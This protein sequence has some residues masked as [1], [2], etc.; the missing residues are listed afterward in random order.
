MNVGNYQ[1]LEQIGMT[2]GGP[3][4]LARELPAGTSALLKLPA[5]D[6]AADGLRRE[7]GLL[8]SLDAPEILKPLALLEE[9]PHLALVLEAFAGEGLDAV[10]ARP[11]QLGLPKALALALQAARALAA[12][13]AA[14]IVHGDIQPANFLLAHDHDEVPL[15]DVQ[16][17]L[18]DLSRAT[19]REDAA[20]ARTAA[21]RDW[22][23]VSPEQTGRMNRPA[24]HRTDFYSLGV[25]LYRLLTGQ[26]PFEADDPLEWVHC[27]LA[28]KPVPP[29]EQIS[30]VPA[31]V[32][33]LVLKLL[34]KL[35][36]ERYQSAHGLLADLEQCLAQWQ[37]AGEITPFALGRRDVA[38][39][40]QIPLKL[41]GRE[42][43]RAALLAAFEAVAT[44]GAATLVTVAGYSGG[45]KS[46][47][48][49]TL[50]Q[51]VVARRG[52]FQAGKFDQYQRDIPYATLA[53]AFDG[54]VRHLLGESEA[55]IAHW[56]QTLH[57]ALAPNAQLMLRLIP[58]LELV[59]G[60]QPSVPELPPQQAQARFQL[61][62]RHFIGVFA[63]QAH[64]LVL[65]L[66]D[67]QW[68][69]AGT[70]ALLGDLATDP[71]VRYL[72]LVGAYRDNEVDGNHPLM[73]G[74]ET[75][76]QAGGATQHIALTALALG[77]VA[78][79][80]ADALHC[81]PAEAR[82]LAQLVWDKTGGNPFFIR[83]F[84][85]AL[86][87]EKLL[88]FDA[89][90]GAWRWDLPRIQAKGFTDNIADLMVGKL[91]RLPQETQAAL[92]RFACLGSSA[93]LATL[94]L[95][96]GESGAATQAA[97]W[98]ALR[99]GFVRRSGDTY[100]FLHD[101][102][103]EAAYSLIP[104]AERPAAHLSIGRL[105]AARTPAEDVERN[106]FDIVNQLNP[107][108]ALI[109][110]IEERETVA[111][112]NLIA[113]QR[114]KRSTAYA[115]ALKFLAG[116]GAL[117]TQERW[118]R[119]YDLAFALE[120]NRAECEFQTG[121]TEAAD[122]RLSALARRAGTLTDLAAVACL[123]IELYITLDLTDRAVDVSLEYLRQAGIDWSA[124]PAKDEVEQEVQ[125]FWRQLGEQSIEDLI[126]LPLMS[127]PARRA[128]FDVLIAILPP[129]SIT[130]E[131]LFWLAIARMANL[132]LE[133]GHCDSSSAGYV[134]FAWMLEGRFGDYQTAYR[135]GKL[136]YDLMEKRGLMRFEARLCL[137]FGHFVTPWTR[138]VRTSRP[139]L[140]RGMDAANRD[141][142]LTFVSY[143][144]FNLVTNLLAAGDPLA[145]CERAT[146]TAL[147]FATKV[148]FGSV[149][150]VIT[151]QQ[152]L[153]RTLRGL[154]SDLSSFND[155]QF[156][157][158][159]FEQHLEADPRLAL[160]ACLYWIRKLQAR[161][162]AGDYASAMQAA[163]KAEALLWTS[164]SYFEHAEYH[165]YGALARAALYD[166][167][168]AAARAQILSALQVHYDQLATWAE[169]GPDNF[170][171]RRALV[172]AEL[173]R[174]EGRELDA[175]RLYERA[176][177]AARDNGF[178]HN[179]A[180]VCEC[181]ARFYLARG[182]AL[183]AQ[184]YLE[185]AR[186]CYARWGADGKVRQLE[187]QYPQLP[188]RST[189][190]PA[191]PLEGEA[192][193]DLLS[194]AKAS[195]AISGQIVIDELID[196]LL[197]LVLESAG[198]QNGCLLLAQGEE[199]VLAAEATVAQQTVQVRR[200]AAPVLSPT[201]LP[202]TLLQYVRRTGEPVL[203]ME[204]SAQHPFAADPYF[205][206]QPPQSVLCLP[207]L[208]QAVLVGLLYL[209]NNLATHAFPPERVQV[210]E[211]LASQAAISLDNARLYA[212]VRDSHARI[213]RLI[214]G[215]LIGIFFWNLQ[216]NIREA[217]E[218]FLEMLGYSRQDLLAGAVNWECITSP[219]YQALDARKAVEVR[220]TRKC[221][222]YEK[223]FLR[224][225]GSRIPVLIGAVLFDDSPDQGVA[226][227]L[228]LSERKQA[229]A[230]RQ[231]RQAAEAANRAKSVFL[232]NMSHELRTPLNSILGYAQILERDPSLDESHGAKA[233]VIRKSG[234]HL[235]TLINDILD[236][237][238]IEAGK[239]EL[240]PE[241][242][243][244]QSYVH[245]IID[246]ASVKA[247]QKGLELACELAPGVPPGI[248]AD[249]KRLRQVLLNLLSN[250]VK[251]TDL[252][253]VALRVRFAPPDQWRFEVADTGV[254]IAP[255]QLET[256]FEPFEQAGDR[257]HRA[258]GTGL[259]LAISRQY[260]RMMGGDIS[261]ESRPG[262]GSTFHLEIR[263]Q[264]VESTS[265]APLE[266]AAAAVA[267][268]TGY[269]GPR[270]K[271]LV[272]D[273]IAENRAVT[274]D[275]LT[276]LGFVVSEA[277]NGRE[278]LD[279]ARRLRPDLILM[280]IAMPQMDGMAAT[281]LLRQTDYCR[282]V[283]VIA[284]TASVSASD[285][286]QCL[287]AGMNAF[288]SKPINADK[289]L[290]LMARL[291]RLEWTFG[292]AH[293]P[294]E[295]GTMVAPPAEEMEVLYLLARLGNMREIMAQADQVA[296]LDER[297]RPFADRLM[298]LA[299]SYQSKAVLHL[300]EAH[301]QASLVEHAPR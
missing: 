126:D 263:A 213:Q 169:S 269:A 90:Q 143:C 280:D 286:E 131:K 230:E 170:E 173:A 134:W 221:T 198:A 249:A 34:A 95:I 235:L 242:L 35:P 209:E 237:A 43:E 111:E 80:A 123:R 45:G 74:L 189:D 298:A 293:A 77:D 163:A 28:R 4:H 68:G 62:F 63:T 156:D 276:P 186:A 241:E 26:L 219:E 277:A 102:F 103:Q 154:T 42:R 27:H 246:I 66:D 159:Q 108:S 190:A 71:D 171:I 207:V 184:A 179:E 53:Q 251:F 147:A 208:R 266:A 106:I 124:H 54:L 205:A 188:A 172:A 109:T 199:L 30:T 180:I 203:L 120:I 274:I 22:A 175:Q 294:E 8:Q 216:G 220:T 226:F 256:F 9:G 136:G 181:A 16:L 267:N 70:L 12:L 112:L 18:A 176:I 81:P 98:E 47:L 152:R 227:V 20:S 135:F 105:L 288:L 183:P 7:Y 118:Q 138:H 287:A 259:G 283:P 195:Q 284:V 38:D 69:D 55:G 17:K 223:E 217:N 204:A 158:A 76:R 273:D 238:K 61:V 10:L 272:V 48:I 214:E 212:D 141:G 150:D 84:L 119:R 127:D 25:M 31:A 116:G 75:I 39:R 222:P 225:D 50:H 301:R 44:T 231:A 253:Q 202:L 79:L 59:I 121:A 11:P 113:G 115:T 92:A 101:R 157:E 161:V 168:C 255:A 292:A 275:L 97:L 1:I 40:F 185:Q 260:A 83:Q 85:A 240:Y 139:L 194:V 58:R 64:P 89:D 295:A 117:L 46:A 164:H 233:K 258:G 206:H 261:V 239:L 6:N 182:L 99:A 21:G 201:H 140:R 282:E 151:G 82:P 278:G 252:G 93:D 197:R 296:R 32:S 178:V 19:A 122:D 144:Q 146:D 218:A 29:H 129:A 57:E 196:T 177:A 130:D 254:G 264:A 125:R 244:V 271:I 2:G 270:R 279:A 86:A 142:D 114:A 262:Q 15:A 36:E 41:Y 104:E 285:S 149:V 200:P 245:D 243:H 290:E 299:A 232:A 14:G 160:A 257:Q 110:S 96:R 268:V 191:G 37:A 224:K 5:H 289:L 236:L 56:R 211:L 187:E 229:E 73:R 153:I 78:Q 281:R 133:Y 291:L 100:T 132:S 88:Q 33:A 145:E 72:L 3:L 174:I 13:H 23:Y 250:A 137:I 60:P 210:L 165:F 24:D 166:A 297:Y 155:E 247:A 300:V 234:E 91:A 67:L 192:R 107:G 128:T 51:P 94:S 193:L 265:G 162:L 248:R 49:E 65:F 228:D 215:N 87:E 148:R 52:Y 167:A